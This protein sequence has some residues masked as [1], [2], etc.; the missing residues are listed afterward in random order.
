MKKSKSFRRKRSKAPVVLWVTL[1]IFILSL[2]V[3]L[4]FLSHLPREK[5]SLRRRP[6]V[7]R[8]AVTQKVEPSREKAPSPER[9]LKTAVEDFLFLNNLEFSE[10]AEKGRLLF[11]TLAD[12]Q[13][14]PLLQEKITLFFHR[15]GYLLSAKVLEEEKRYL[16]E[17][18]PEKSRESLVAILVVFKSPPVKAKPIT[19]SPRVALIIDDIGNSADTTRLLASSPLPLALSILPDSP[20]RDES[21]ET[22]KKRGKE[23]WLHIPMEPIPSNGNSMDLEGFLK[24]SMRKE[25]LQNY[26]EVFLERVPGAVGANNHT[27]SLFTQDRE[28]MRTVLETLSRHGLLFVDSRTSGKSVAFEE[29]RH[30]RVPSLVRDVFVDGE[31]EEMTLL[32]FRHLLALAKKN[33]TALGIGHPKE[34][35]LA[36]ILRRLPELLKQSGVT[37]VRPSELIVP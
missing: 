10:T 20:Y 9:E 24:V 21:I 1:A 34:E 6:P 3:I 37:M 5:D 28:K 32:N 7:R 29:A 17:I 14:Y 12:P 11:K 25:L 35:T 2:G 36:V 13:D 19:P 15:K 8:S 30:M 27:G 23:I 31:S 16:W 33:G 26:L 4:L 18:F 22:A